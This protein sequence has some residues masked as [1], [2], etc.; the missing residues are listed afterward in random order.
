MALLTYTDLRSVTTEA[1]FSLENSVD[2]ALS[3]F[4]A[5]GKRETRKGVYGIIKLTLNQVYESLTL[6]DND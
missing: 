4:Y 2:R 5:T 3:Y 1:S 6:I